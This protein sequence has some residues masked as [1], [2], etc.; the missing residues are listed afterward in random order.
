MKASRP[1]TGD[2]VLAAMADLIAHLPAGDHDTNQR[3]AAVAASLRELLTAH[4]QPNAVAEHLHDV[5]E[6][7]HDTAGD[8]RADPQARTAFLI[9][10]SHDLRAPIGA[11]VQQ[12]QLL[13]SEN[14]ADDIRRRSVDALR[15]NAGLLSRM[16]DDLVD[17]ERFAL[18]ELHL[19]RQPTRLSTILDVIRRD[20][21]EVVV[22]DGDSQASVDV[23]AMSRAIRTL[24]AV[25]GRR[26]PTSRVIVRG[27]VCDGDIEISVRAESETAPPSGASDASRSIDFRL[28][29]ALVE[30]H[31]GS[32]TQVDH[33]VIV[34]LPLCDETES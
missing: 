19:E 8:L 7:E 18:G 3:A 30:A 9:A 1:S 26:Y 13:G 15:E 28:I 12:A 11:L 27:R 4:D 2:D 10:L 23:K 5:T 6:T 22:E 24:V 14:L 29:G 21:A 17:I 34:L 25:K 20:D 33:G 16:M 31:D 32:M